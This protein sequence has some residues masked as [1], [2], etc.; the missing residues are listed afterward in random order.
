MNSKIVSMAL[1]TVLTLMF[2]PATCALGEARSSL[3]AEV[4][5]CRILGRR[6]YNVCEQSPN[7]RQCHQ[8]SKAYNKLC[9]EDRFRK[10]VV[11]PAD[12]SCIF[13]ARGLQCAWD[14]TNSFHYLGYICTVERLKVLLAS[15]RCEGE[16]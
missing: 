13:F 15:S 9:R 10:R 4:N 16:L 5:R 3:E 7:R 8:R 6:A 2:E 11:I 14:P 1:I 12:E